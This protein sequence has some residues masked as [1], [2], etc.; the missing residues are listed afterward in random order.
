MKR[1]PFPISSSKFVDC[2]DLV[3]VDIWGPFGITL[4]FGR[5]YFLTVVDNKYRFP[6]IYFMKLK[7]EVRHLL[8]S[9][10]KMIELQFNKSM[11]IARYDNG[12]EFLMTNFFQSTGII[13]QISCPD[14]PQQNVVVEKKYQ[15]ILNIARSLVFQSKLPLCL[16]NFAINH[17]VFILNRIPSTKL[18][19]QSP[20]Q[21]L[22]NKLPTLTHLRIFGSLYCATTQTAQRK[23]EGQ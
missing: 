10:V 4:V 19:N 7:S 20:Y 14:T 11:K 21:V 17:A 23:K 3:H 1:L 18:D 5:K 16:W 22:H 12:K 8:Q 15:H 13:H 2:F 6:W 9:F